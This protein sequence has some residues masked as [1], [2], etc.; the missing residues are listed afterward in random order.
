[1]LSIQQTSAII[2]TV[3]LLRLL[4]FKENK[5]SNH[6]DLNVQGCDL[7]VHEV[8]RGNVSSVCIFW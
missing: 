3:R 1:M 2:V 5:S 8:R 6:K 7:V 4:P